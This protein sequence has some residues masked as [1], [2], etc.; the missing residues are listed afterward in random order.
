MNPSLSLIGLS[1]CAPALATDPPPSDTTPRIVVHPDY[2]V[3]RDGDRPHVETMAAAHP[4][5]PKKLL[6]GAITFTRPD[7]GVASKV[8]ASQD[9]GITW[10]DVAFPLQ[11]TMGGADPQVAFTGAGTAIFASL[12]SGPDET[13]RTRSFLHAYRSEDGG[14]SWSDA[15]DL[16]GS[17]DHPMLVADRTAG[18]HAGNLYMSVLYGIEY[19]LGVFR[20]EDDGRSW[21]GPVEFINGEGRRGLNTEQMMVLADG[22][23][24]VTFIEFPNS[25]EMLEEWRERQQEVRFWTATSTDGGVTFSEAQP[26]AVLYIAAPETRELPYS[27]HVVFAADT[28]DR[29]RDRIYAAWP[30]SVG[31][32]LRLFLAHTDDRGASWSE[33]R[34]VDPGA[35]AGTQQFQPTLAV[36][37]EGVVGATWF[38]SRDTQAKMGF[39]QVF[40]ASVDGGATLTEPIRLSSAESKPFGAGNL[41]P[42]PSTFTGTDGELRVNVLSGAGRWIG[43]G[44]YI[45]ITTDARGAFHPVWPDSRSGTYQVYT[46]RV[47]VLTTPEEAPDEPLDLVGEDVTAAIDLVSDPGNLDAE[48]LELQWWIR[49]KNTSERPIHGP[50]ELEIRRFGSGRGD[51]RRELAP[52]ILN[53]ANGKT[54]DGATFVYDQALG[55]DGILAP[56]EVSG[57]MLW[58]LRLQDVRRSPGLHVYATGRR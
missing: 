29:H 51:V 27:V 18:P 50:I 37:R 43:G 15:D 1:F 7:G 54:G 52:E 38:D 39:H 12:A 14:L 22:T 41:L 31:K 9:R 8:Y 30:G 16:G 6:A 13:G 25:L 5:D 11:K 26:G 57:A 58:R 24:V 23:L 2:L 3:S 35:P 34:L 36:N 10:Q 19:R 48:T 32:D 53:A 21:I 47:E 55:S 46:A 28:S 4:R 56:G 42:S 20:S 40:A 17:Y 33:P 44:D 49:L 45:G